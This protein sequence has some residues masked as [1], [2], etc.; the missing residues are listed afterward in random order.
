MS[1]LKTRNRLVNF[2]L[3]QDELESLRMAC[4][5]KGS[6]N[7][8]DFARGAVLEAIES[9]TGPGL[10]IQSRLAALDSKISDLGVTLQCLTDLLRGTLK[11]M[12]QTPP[13][14]SVAALR[15]TYSVE[16]EDA[17]P[18]AAFER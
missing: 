2:R 14:D 7:V 12:V 9:Q 11:G 8:S 10:L 4:L 17:S 6:R 5:V 3:T 16:C 15:R 1:V 13:R 18:R